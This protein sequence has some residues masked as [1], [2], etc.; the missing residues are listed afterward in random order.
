M[1]NPPCPVDAAGDCSRHK[2]RHFGAA[3]TF[4]K[5]SDPLSVQYRTLWDEQAGLGNGHYV[6][7]FLRTVSLP[8]VHLGESLRLPD[9]RAKTTES[10]VPT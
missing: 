6:Q 4:A 10:R 8:C 7:T 1:V 2:V 9:G 5:G 3:L